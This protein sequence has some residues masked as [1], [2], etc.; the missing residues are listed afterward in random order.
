MIQ[1]HPFGIRERPAGSAG[2]RL[3]HCG[4][5][6]VSMPKAGPFPPVLRLRRPLARFELE[7]LPGGAA[8][9]SY[10]MGGPRR[11]AG[12]PCLSLHRGRCTKTVFSMNGRRR[13]RPALAA[14][15]PV[16]G[17]LGAEARC[18]RQTIGEAFLRAGLGPLPMRRMGQQRLLAGLWRAGHQ[19]AAPA[20][21]LAVTLLQCTRCPTPRAT[22][23][24]PLF[25]TTMMR[26]DQC[27]K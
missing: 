17:W 6:D 8:A 9:A 18:G 7:D 13:L 15:V 23:R 16:A 20:A 21:H 4:I 2:F 19:R 24:R 22:Q 27:R 10:G 11:L 5:I 3:G 14:A 12:A 25:V 1:R 26:A